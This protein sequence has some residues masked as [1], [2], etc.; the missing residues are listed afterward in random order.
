MLLPAYPV[1]NRQTL[2]ILCCYFN[3]NHK[4]QLARLSDK[5]SSTVRAVR[6]VRAVRGNR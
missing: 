5:N 6:A 3:S 4:M 1:I 2:K